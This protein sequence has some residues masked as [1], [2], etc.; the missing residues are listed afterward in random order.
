MSENTDRIYKG[1]KLEFFPDEY[2]VFDLE[3]TGTNIKKDK[4]IEIGAIKI[5]NNEIIDK[6]ETLINPNIPIPYKATEINHITDEMVK[7]APTFE[8]IADKLYIFLKDSILA[9]YNADT[10]DINL[11]YDAYEELGIKFT[12]DF[13]DILNIAK[14]ILPELNNYKLEE[15]LV[16]YYNIEVKQSHRAI[17]DCITEYK[18]FNELKIDSVNKRHLNKYYAKKKSTKQDTSYLKFPNIQLD[19]FNANKVTFEQKRFLVTGRTE[20]REGKSFE[21]FIRNNKGI[22]PTLNKKTPQIDYLF[23][24]LQNP[25]RCNDKLNFITNKIQTVLNQKNLGEDVKIF[26]LRKLEHYIDNKRT[27]SNDD[28]ITFF[29]KQIKPDFLKLS[30]LEI[31]ENK[32]GYNSIVIISEPTV[33]R[34]GDT[35]EKLFARFSINN[36]NNY[37]AFPSSTEKIFKKHQLPYYTVKSDSWI[38]ISINEFYYFSEKVIKEI[39]NQL[40]IRAFNYPSFGCCSKYDECTKKGYCVHDDLIYA[41]VACQYKKLIEN[42]NKENEN[43]SK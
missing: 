1:K 19:E 37:I 25:D 11:L 14:N 12:N 26:D 2:I 13:I 4:I 38:R 30:K 18:V 34:F 22:V 7:D 29:E 20:Q 17:S 32:S 31:K 21:N 27:Y 39:I 43:E 35:K 36:K 28:L 41:N 10:F 5:K 42:F 9:G 8:E 23:V 16:P 3:T 33:W 15:D 6:F 40:F 24:G